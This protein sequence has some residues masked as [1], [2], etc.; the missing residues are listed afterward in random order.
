M[1][2]KFLSIH[3]IERARLACIKISRLCLGNK[4]TPDNSIKRKFLFNTQYIHAFSELEFMC[5]ANLKLQ[6]HEVLVIICDGLPYSEREI[7]D[8]PNVNPYK[9]CSNRTQRYCNAYG[10]DYIKINDFWITNSTEIQQ[11]GPSTN[12]APNQWFWI[13][14]SIEIK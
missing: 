6:G 1:L 13:R 9:K 8:L 12:T 4:V 14:N 7:A 11:I 3:V 2:K 5:A 10:L